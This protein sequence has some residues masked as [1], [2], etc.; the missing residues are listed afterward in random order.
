MLY[1]YGNFAHVFCSNKVQNVVD[2]IFMKYFYKNYEI[3][4]AFFLN[5]CYNIFAGKWRHQL[6]V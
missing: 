2:V 5:L 1:F 4:V 3:I 6:E